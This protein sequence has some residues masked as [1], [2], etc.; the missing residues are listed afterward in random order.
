MNSNLIGLGW[1]GLVAAKTYLD[2]NPS[3]KVIILDSSSTIGG[4]WAEDRL[5]PGLK[6]NNLLGT[7]EYSDFPMDEETFN[8]QRGQHIPGQ[9]IHDYLQKYAETFGLFRR[10][11]FNSKVETAEQHG[12]EGWLLMIRGKKGNEIDRKLLARKLII[13]TGLTSEPFLAHFDGIAKFDAPLFH[14]KDFAQH[15][16]SLISSKSVVVYGGGKSGWDMAYTYASAGVKVDWVIRDSGRG[17]AWMSPPYVTP[18]KKWIEKLV[19]TR[20]LTWFSPCIWGDADGYSGARRFL[21]NTFIGRWIVRSFWWILGNDVLSLNNYD[22][23]P[24]TAKLKPWTNI[25]FTGSSTS[26]LNY[27]T[28]F[29]D[30]VRDGQIKV[31]IAEI[32]HLSRGTVHLS[33]GEDL[34]TD[35]LVCCTGWKYSQPIV[36]SPPGFEKSLG[37]PHVS[38]DDLG[39]QISEADDIILERFPILKDQP[40]PQKPTVEARRAVS[41]SKQRVNQPF[42][43][44]RFMVPPS[45]IESHN[46]GFAGMLLNFSTPLV[47]Q[48]QALWLTAYLDGHLRINKTEEEIMKETIL[49]SQFGK[50]R[51]SQGSGSRFPDFVFDALPYLDLLLGDLGL[52]RHRKRWWWEEWFQAYGP[53]DYKDLV[54]EW[55]WRLASNRSFTENQRVNLQR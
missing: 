49:H 5:Y 34:E 19:H 31:H 54:L 53:E 11:R 32:T 48:T 13:A 47:A 40:T 1:F 25:F 37:L 29:F 21:Q 46:I 38:H 36:F 27:P 2:V 42:R 10:I 6:S 23:H 28:D 30:F 22:A 41:D 3:A 26:I 45:N 4:V 52:E 20:F 33:T 17:A 51:C 14:Y 24:E 15:T 44:Y 50:W 7:Y 16:D 9:A 35:A 43:L 18:L 55:K 12:D 8:V 39:S